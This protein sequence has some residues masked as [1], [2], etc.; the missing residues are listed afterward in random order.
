MSSLILT[1]PS[2]SSSR[3]STRELVRRAKSGGPSAV[4]PLF[5]RL[6]GRVRRIIHADTLAEPNASS[7]EVSVGGTTVPGVALDQGLYT[8]SIDFDD[9]LFSPALNGAQQ[10]SITAANQRTTT[11]VSRE[12]MVPFV[13]D[14]DGPTIVIANPAP[15]NLISGIMTVEATI[16]DN[17]GILQGSTVA[18]LAGVNDFPLTSA[19]AGIYTGEFDT[20]ILGTNMVF[21][22]LIVRAQDTTGNQ[23]SNGRVV[24]LD[25]V[26]PTLSL[27]SADMRESRI[28]DGDLVCSALFDPLGDD[29]VD[30]GEAVA[31]LFEVRARI[32][33]A[34][35]GATSGSGVAI[36]IADN[37]DTSVQ[38]FLLDNSADALIVDT[39]GDGTCDEINP[40]LVPTSV[41]QSSDEVAL[42]DLSPI[43][44]TGA[45]DFLFNVTD[46]ASTGHGDC[47]AG[48]ALVPNPDLCLT[49]DA[50]RI[51]QRQ[52]GT[53]PVIYG[54]P[55]FAGNACLGNAIDAVATNI[56]DGWAC[57]AVRGADKLGNVGI[58][59]PLRACID[60]DLNE[61][62]CPTLGTIT[63]T[64]L[65]DC[66][67]TYDPSTN[68][69][70]ATNNCT[71]PPEFGIDRRR[72][73]L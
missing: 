65:P 15:G 35:N 21:P 54:V 27:D 8:V 5:A 53:T 52:G 4:G 24:S 29:S 20:R 32:E 58:S 38:L 23:S 42:I 39:D 41:P 16:T 2:G 66:T 37:D 50:S 69:V 12:T 56:A 59:A 68:T 48:E 73:D 7:I 34:G 62:E 46:F 19:G 51:I 6:R 47:I 70:D 63:S 14:S 26:S 72:I 71:L 13:V 9:P 36:P 17:A 40:L 33:D 61:A 67:G 31:Q 43:L 44:P 10:L 55:P 25:N 57:L 30:D 60:S 1:A 28:D 18:T 3:I 22:N 11:A 49:V 64:G 45:S